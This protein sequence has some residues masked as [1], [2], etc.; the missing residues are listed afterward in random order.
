MAQQDLAFRFLSRRNAILF[1]GSFLMVMGFGTGSRPV[2]F[3]AELLVITLIGEYLLDAGRLNGL[4]VRRRHYPRSFEGSEVD[5]HLEV[6]NTS[7]RALYLLE[8][9]D[10]FP[11][12]SNYHI[13]QM[14]T[15]VG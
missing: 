3:L 15:Y 7:A 8:L 6:S 2:I 13:H 1:L 10:S 14:A 12:G 4:H 5:V 9:T 11:P